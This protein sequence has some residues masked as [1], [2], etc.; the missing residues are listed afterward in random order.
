VSARNPQAAAVWINVASQ[1][2]QAWLA[3]AV[4]IS[5][6]CVGIHNHSTNAEESTQT[7]R[8]LADSRAN[9]SVRFGHARGLTTVQVVIQH[10]RAASLL[11]RS[12]AGRT[13]RLEEFANTAP[14]SSPFARPKNK[15]A[16][17]GTPTIK[18]VLPS[19]KEKRS[20]DDLFVLLFTRLA[21]QGI[22]CYTYKS[23][24]SGGKYK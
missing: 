23:V 2:F 15:K 18:Q 7:Y 22:V 20:T 19:K 21:L 11:A 9:V 24:L 8:T 3:Y 16:P 4:G 17:Q 1:R 12:F 14:T 5:G 13:R 10:P 6:V